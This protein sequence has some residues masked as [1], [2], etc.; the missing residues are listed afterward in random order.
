MFQ[1]I[2]SF[3]YPRHWYEIEHFEKKLGKTFFFTLKCYTQ[4][5]SH[6]SVSSNMGYW[7]R[8]HVYKVLF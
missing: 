4:F 2:S 7:H 6:S 8:L 3:F 1:A 5:L